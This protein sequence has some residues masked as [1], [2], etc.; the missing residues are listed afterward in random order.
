MTAVA[1]SVF[2][3]AQFNQFVRDNL[4]ET[5]PAKATTSGSYFVGTGLNSI[6]ERTSSTDIVETSQTTTSTTYADLATVGP[7]VTV[8][9][10]VFALILVT[11]DITNNTAGESGRMTFEVSGASTVTPLDARALR[12]TIPSVTGAGNVRSSVLTAFGTLTAGVNVFTAKYRASGGTATFA[13]RR[14]TV[15]P[16]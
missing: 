14:L 12:V 4:N 9:T 16:Y 7:T 1:G 10:G 6:A 8:T 2:T 3:A 11:G 15:L 13:N 5:A